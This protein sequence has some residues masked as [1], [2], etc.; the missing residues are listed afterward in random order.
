MKRWLV[1]VLVFGLCSAVVRADVTV[2]QTTTIE[3]GMAAMAGG[4]G[5]PPTPKVTVRV[6]GMK[7]RTDMELPTLN[8]S[9]I[10]DLVAKQ[11]IM[12][13]HDQKTAQMVDA[14]APA[15]PAGTAPVTATVKLDA[16][17]TPT[18]KSQVID[19]FK[20]DEY[21]FS[22]TMSMAEAG[23][24]QIPPEAAEML[25]DVT[26]IMK[27]SMWVAKDAPGAAEY[28]A[29]QKALA[30]SDLA[31]ATSKL[32]GINLPGMDKMTKAMAGVDGLNYLTVMDM[33]IEGSGQ[34]ADMM[35]QM[36]AMKLTTK[37][38]SLSADAISD[39]QF[40]IP[41]GYTVIK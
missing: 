14:A 38:T 30:K 37:V 24:T 1:T 41:E 22:T 19:G 32:A 12:L 18:G 11:M 39:D 25:K 20:C 31:G 29:F 8:M 15:S 36:G 35:R 40:K 4:G 5:A 27:G 33:T 21:T 23:G 16:T 10:T 6:K 3:G 7:S 13:R 2:V 9:S 34:I 26:M 28:V 17:V